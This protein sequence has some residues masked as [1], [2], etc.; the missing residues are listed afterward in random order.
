MQHIVA[1]TTAR[2]GRRAFFGLLA[3]ALG[4]WLSP[5]RATPWSDG[6][7]APGDPSR[8]LSRFDVRGG[9]LLGRDDR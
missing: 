4:G 3:A 7:G 9:W 8:G 5:A 2:A 6:H 1:T